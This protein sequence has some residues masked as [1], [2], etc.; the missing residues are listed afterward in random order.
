MPEEPIYLLE[1][2]GET[3][4]V[5]LTIGTVTHNDNTELK[6]V[7]ADL[8]SNKTKN[9]ILDLSNTTYVSSIVLASL[10]FMQK[11]IKEA[12]GSLI[13][14]GVRENVKEILEMTSL[15]KILDIVSTRNEAL[16]R[17]SAK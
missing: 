15:N 17:I 4:T 13:I 2:I 14:C 10:V 16:S 7:F 3:V 5:T 1:N 11:S 12:S 8:L 9:I 6:K